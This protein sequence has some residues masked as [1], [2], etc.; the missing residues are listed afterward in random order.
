MG[1]TESLSTRQKRVWAEKSMSEEY[2]KH[3]GIRRMLKD[4][5]PLKFICHITGK[6]ES[7][8]L[9]IGKEKDFYI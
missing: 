4:D 1:K 3:H 2:Q 5:V 8:I 9:R 6:T 7:E